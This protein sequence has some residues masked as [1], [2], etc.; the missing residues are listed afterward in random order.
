MRVRKSRYFFKSKSELAHALD[1]FHPHG[2]RIRGRDVEYKDESG[3]WI[4]EYYL[5]IRDDKASGWW[6]FH[7]DD[8][9]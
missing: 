1:I 5:V 4:G 7:P 2:W 6:I 3:R 9:K 8:A